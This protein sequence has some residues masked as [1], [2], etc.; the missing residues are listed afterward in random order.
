MH[1]QLDPLEMVKRDK[2][3]LTLALRRLA[4]ILKSKAKPSQN[5]KQMILVSLTFSVSGTVGV[6]ES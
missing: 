2:G 6:I 1:E 3:D 5:Q 4:E